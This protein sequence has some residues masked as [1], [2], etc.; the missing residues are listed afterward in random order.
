MHSSDTIFC[1][2]RATHTIT[3]SHTNYL[4][5]VSLKVH[6]AHFATVLGHSVTVPLVDTYNTDTAN[7]FTCVAFGQKKTIYI[8]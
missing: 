6:L 4:K 2:L 3:N 1:V 7:P 5:R 8:V